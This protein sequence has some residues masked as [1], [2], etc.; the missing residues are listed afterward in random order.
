MVWAAGFII[1]EMVKDYFI[2]YAKAFLMWP[3]DFLNLLKW[4]KSTLILSYRDDLSIIKSFNI[5]MIL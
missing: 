5:I 3:I 2:S 1:P 4:L